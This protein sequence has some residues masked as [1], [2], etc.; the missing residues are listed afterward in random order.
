MPHHMATL[1]KTVK[2][3]TTNGLPRYCIITSAKSTVL[4][5]ILELALC[6]VTLECFNSNSLSIA[7]PIHITATFSCKSSRELLYKRSKLAINKP[8]LY[9][10]RY[11]LMKTIENDLILLQRN[12]KST[13]TSFHIFIII[14][15]WKLSLDERNILL[16][17]N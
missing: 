13:T 15:S 1:Y 16:F 7:L 6:K 3:S 8:H 4:L 12:N 10:F 2:C 5:E 9:L 17:H 11:K 14:D